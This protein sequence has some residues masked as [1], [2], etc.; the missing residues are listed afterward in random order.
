[1]GDGTSLAE[2]KFDRWW[3]Q[4]DKL[5][6]DKYGL[7]VEDF[8]DFPFMDCFEDGMTAKEF[9]EEEVEPVI[10]DGIHDA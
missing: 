4:V 5:V 6:T 7:G 10:Q 8:G 1:M 2:M 9:F 3:Q